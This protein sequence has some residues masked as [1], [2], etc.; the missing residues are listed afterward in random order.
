MGLRSQFRVVI[1]LMFALTAVGALSSPAAAEIV[2]NQCTGTC[3]YW[4]V[5]DMQ[6]GGKGAV[7]VYLKSNTAPNLHEITVRPPLMHG[8]YPQKTKVGW[9]FKIQRSPV[10]G[11]FSTIYTSSWQTAK[12]NDS[13]PAYAGHGFSRRA[14][15]A[16]SNPHGFFRVWVEMRWWN[17][18]GSAVE[19]TARVQY[20]WYKAVQSGNTPYTDESYCLQ[21][22]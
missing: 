7:C 8:N 6:S 9:R 12:A 2:L 15:F 1:A 18:S 13:I 10:S 19:G 16:P 14:W 3:G 11:T 4:Q 22:F 5:T 21:D 17:Q 20:L